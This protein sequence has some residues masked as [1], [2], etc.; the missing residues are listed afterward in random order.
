MMSIDL[1]T[2]TKPIF[3]QS[4]VGAVKDYVDAEW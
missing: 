3:D 1:G 4:V 2:S